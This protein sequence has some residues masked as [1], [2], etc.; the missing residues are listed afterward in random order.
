M[1]DKEFIGKTIK[2]F[3]PVSM[4]LDN[5]KECL[6]DGRFYYGFRI[7][8]TDGSVLNIEERTQTG[9]ILVY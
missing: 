9:S 3:D 1:I 7:V 5:N 4:E 8:F 2:S 6:E